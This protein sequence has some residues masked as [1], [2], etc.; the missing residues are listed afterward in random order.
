MRIVFSIGFEES[1]NL[2]LEVSVPLRGSHAGPQCCCRANS[3]RVQVSFQCVPYTAVSPKCMTWKCSILIWES[4]SVKFLQHM[5]DVP[6]HQ[7][8]VP[9]AP[10]KEIPTGLWDW[11]WGGQMVS[12]ISWV[13]SSLGGVTP[14][15]PSQVYM[16][17]SPIKLA[18]SLSRMRY[19]VSFVWV[20]WLTI[21][22]VL[23]VWKPSSECRLF[24]Q[25]FQSIFC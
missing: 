18:V 14:V 16:L 22:E 8:H 9:L 4:L 10:A 23:S 5:A 3:V 21:L 25:T 15:A 7:Q 6:V 17:V 24:F 19:V 1:F 13:N 20:L 12:A 11:P 2:L